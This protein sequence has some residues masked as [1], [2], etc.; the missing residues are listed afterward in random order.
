[1]APSEPSTRNS[2]GIVF[3]QTRQPEIIREFYVKRVGCSVW[4]EQGGCFILQ[5]GNLLLGFCDRD[6]LDSTGVYTF[7]YTS[8]DDVDRMYERLKD[9][10]DGPPRDNARYRIYHFYSRDPEG[11]MIEFQYFNHPIPLY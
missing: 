7:F 2:G 1:M 5:H 9:I 11:R 6:A 10:S 3:L 4:L 8:R